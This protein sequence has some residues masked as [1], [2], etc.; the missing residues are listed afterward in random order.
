MVCVPAALDKEGLVQ[1]SPW[2]EGP[3]A[4]LRPEP[5]S[6]GQEL[7]AFLATSLLTTPT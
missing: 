5:D 7:C 1:A 4:E 2:C 6:G 3:G